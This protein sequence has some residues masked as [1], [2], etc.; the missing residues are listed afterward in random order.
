MQKLTTKA[1]VFLTFLKLVHIFGVDLIR[2][3][4]IFLSPFDE[5]L[6]FIDD[7]CKVIAEKICENGNDDDFG[8]NGQYPPPSANVSYRHFL[9]VFL[10]QCLHSLN[11]FDSMRPNP[12][13]V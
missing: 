11:A 12:I 7:Y 5:N 3:C 13:L 8:W 9:Q 10:F 1:P 6:L 4:V 2:E